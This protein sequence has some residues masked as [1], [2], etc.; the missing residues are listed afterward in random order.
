[1]LLEALRERVSGIRRSARMDHHAKPMM[2]QILAARDC[3]PLA[4]AQAGDA[5][6]SE[7][8]IDAEQA[9]ELTQLLA[10]LEKLESQFAT[11]PD[12]KPYIPMP[13]ARM[14][15]RHPT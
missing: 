12:A 13:R 5:Q 3:A 14:R 1:V 6:A 2:Q 7:T 9:A 10:A 4:G 8:P 15:L 11:A